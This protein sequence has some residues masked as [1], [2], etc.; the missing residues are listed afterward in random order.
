MSTTHQNSSSNSNF[1]TIG[2]PILRTKSDAQSRAKYLYPHCAGTAVWHQTGVP[3]NEGFLGSRNHLFERLPLAS[4]TDRQ[5]K[6]HDHKSTCK[7]CSTKTRRLLP[8]CLEMPI[9]MTK[10]RL[11]G[12]L[13]HQGCC[14][15]LTKVMSNSNTL[16]VSCVHAYSYTH[17]KLS[18]CS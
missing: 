15:T 17:A 13:R 16:N 6:P 2:D 12:T 9:L 7:N 14:Q 18:M 1:N 8:A 5:T 3:K 10:K 11:E 4:H